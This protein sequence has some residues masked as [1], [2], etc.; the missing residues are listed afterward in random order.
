MCCKEVE[1]HILL[2]G[3]R[4]EMTCQTQLKQILL[5][6]TTAKVLTAAFLHLQGR[7]WEA[8]WQFWREVGLEASPSALRWT[9]SP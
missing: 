1:S 2:L 6:A 4:L 8:I 7:R 3:P 5:D 9:E